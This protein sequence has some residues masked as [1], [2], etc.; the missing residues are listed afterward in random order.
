[1]LDKTIKFIAADM[2]GTLLDENG[3]LDPGFFRLY[4]RLK[5][6]NI[7]FSP[8][9][10]RQYFS[11]K[12]TFSPVANDMI[13][14]ADNG[15]LV[16][17]GGREIYSSTIDTQSALEVVKLAKDIDGTHV[18]LCGKKSAY[19]DTQCTSALEEIKKYYHECLQVGDLLHVDDEFIKVAI[20][21][22]D[23]SEDRIY[24]SINEAFG[25]SLKVV[26]S[27]KIWLDVMNASASKG[28][29]IRHLQT[30]LGFTADE[31]MTFGD[32]FND[33]EM[34][35]ASRYSY[36]MANAHEGVKQY[37]RYQAPSNK[38]NGV[39]QVIEQYLDTLDKD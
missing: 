8:A 17:Q 15:T 27:S 20:L 35:Q 16:M 31:T 36:A 6:K 39:I 7:L 28:D 12:S 24:P 5:Q 37:A 14:I 29:A 33:V 1:M 9:S 30:M 11:L 21:H 38:E 22:F 25:Q 13:F 34:L 23:G 2:D 4:E 3:Q 10:G 26:V 18:V 19:V 32:Y